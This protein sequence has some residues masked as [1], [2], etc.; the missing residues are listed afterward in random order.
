MKK[1]LLVGGVLMALLAV[2]LIISVLGAGG[3]F[4]KR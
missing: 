2:V 1:M 3:S 4:V